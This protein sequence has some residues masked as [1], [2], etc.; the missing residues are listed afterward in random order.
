VRYSARL[1]HYT[2]LNLT[3]LDVLDSFDEIP[4]AV[5][6][7][8]DGAPVEGPPASIDALAR[9]KVVYHTLPGWRSQGATAGIRDWEKL[10]PNARAYVEFI[11]S[12]VG[13]SIRWIGTGPAREDMVVRQP[14]T[15]SSTQGSRSNGET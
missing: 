12:T 11:E 6:Y 5:E 14:S 1:N 15:Q 2:A 4:V 9:V 13:V 8:L 3:K 7:E 10:P